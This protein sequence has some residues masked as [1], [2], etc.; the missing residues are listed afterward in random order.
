MALLDA[1]CVRVSFGYDKGI[2]GRSCVLEG[3]GHVR[4]IWFK[5]EI[6][7]SNEFQRLDMNGAAITGRIEISFTA[8]LQRFFL[9]PSFERRYTCYSYIAKNGISWQ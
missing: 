4:I 9:E 3:T 5:D 8:Y 7:K 6:V 2:S 1:F